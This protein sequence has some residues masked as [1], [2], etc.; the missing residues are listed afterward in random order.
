[1]N[2]RPAIDAEVFYR[3]LFNMASDAI[4]TVCA[5]TGR[6]M[7]ANRR[8]SALFG[9]S[10]EELLAMNVH[11][12]YLQ[13]EA[14][15][16]ADFEQQVT[17]AGCGCGIID[18]LPF[19]TREQKTVLVNVSCSMVESAGRHVVNMICR[20]VT[21]ERQIEAQLVEYTKS[22]ESQ[23][24]EKKRQLEE[25]QT[26]LIQTEKM[27]ALGN[28]VAGVAHEIN[29]PLGSVNSNNDVI[30]LSFRR[31]SE[32]LAALPPAVDDR[33]PEPDLAEVREIVAEA[34]R[35][36]R[37]ACERIVKIVRSLRSFVRLDE[38]ERKKV[39]IHD[40][41]ESTL[42]LVAHE[43]KRRITV[44]KDFGQVREIECYPNQLNQVFMNMLVNA[45]QSIDSEG[46]IRIRTWEEA[47]TLRISITD[48]GRGIPAEIREKIFDPG[49]TTKKP[50]LGTG[51]GLSICQKIIE[52]HG[53][54][55][56]VV[57]EIGRGT[58]FTIILPLT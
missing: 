15:K 49:F 21:R 1:M 37:I 48:S 24:E 3:D 7:D 51:L 50:G 34:I 54:R 13:E 46:V 10:H 2:G 40:G 30:E 52:K 4:L 58:T 9:Y 57:S 33:R 22:L 41:I 8:A 31:M 44:E 20:D 12:L 39:N 55:I 53:G 17:R 23:Y 27:A 56:D 16:V 26:Q 6:I 42:L 38:A 29:T 32:Y 36:N 5:E 35:T 47:D 19:R 11:E 14:G 25:S 43:L 18:D 28:L 45:A